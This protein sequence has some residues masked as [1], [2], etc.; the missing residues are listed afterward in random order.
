MTF[1][2]SKQF[3]FDASHQLLQLPETHKCHRLHGHT[4]TVIVHLAAAKLDR[5]G[6]VQD[7]ND[8]APIKRYLDEHFDHRHLNDVL[9]YAGMKVPPTAEM[10]A[11]VLYK[12][13]KPQCPQLDAI[14]V[15][16]TPG[17]EA[18]YYE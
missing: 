11:L 9:E 1:K 4:Y 8:L 14:T 15:K 12:I 18:T 6:F 2:I 7:Y 3:T 13:F 16:E 17:T 10:I 5:N